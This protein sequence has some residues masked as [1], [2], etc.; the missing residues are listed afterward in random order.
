MYLKN[1]NILLSRESFKNSITY[2]NVTYLL[3]PLDDEN[4]IS[5]GG[6]SFVYKATDTNNGNVY[7]VKFCKFSE[8]LSKDYFIKR[9]IRFNKEVEALTIAKDLSNVIDFYFDDYKTINNKV[10]HYYLM[11]FAETDL[12]KFLEQNE[13]SE[14]QRFLLC[15]DILEGIIQLHARHIYHRD[16]KPDNIL[17]KN[18]AWKIGDLGLA[19]YRD[20]NFFIDEMGEKIGPIGWLSPEAMNKFYNEGK[21]NTYN[22]DCLIDKKSDVFQLGKLF[23][24]IFQGNIPIGQIKRKDFYISNKR[25]YDTIYKMLLHSKETRITLDEVMDSFK[26]EYSYYGL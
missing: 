19:N 16:L 15:A 8:E 14:Q 3:S 23:W 4:P 24:F 20:S 1:K 25:V 5:K 26:N 21:K 11:E 22:H 12:T 13:I 6:N 7:V 17:F 2:N 18:K 9:L 10:F